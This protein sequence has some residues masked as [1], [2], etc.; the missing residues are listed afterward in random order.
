MYIGD[1]RVSVK[2]LL[3]LCI[4]SLLPGK[5]SPQ[6]ND[7]CLACHSD[8]KM[9]MT[10]NGKEISIFVDSKIIGT[11]THKNLNCISCHVGFNPDDVPHKENIQPIDCKSCHKD[12]PLKHQFHPDMMKKGSGILQETDCKK[13]HGTH[14]VISPKLTS[15]KFNKINLVQT[16]GSCHTSNKDKFVRSAHF[17]AFESGE[18][19]A[20]NCL[21]CHKNP[22]IV[23]EKGRDTLSIKNAQ[24][25]LCLSC[26]LDDPEIRA[27]TSP[28]AGFI[29]SYEQSVHGIALAKGNSRA[30]SCIDCHTSH[31][32]NKPTESISSV[33]KFNIPKTCSKCHGDIAKLYA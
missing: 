32:V 25:K 24:Q 3:L 13:C 33:N 4:F 1:L 8:S 31:E 26:H 18:I 22:A 9:T 16:C 6:T 19:G 14:D 28:A 20:P 2:I 23:Y 30:A 12:A 15:S 29:N 27:K 11:S 5:L 7:D 10:K 21:T 17:K